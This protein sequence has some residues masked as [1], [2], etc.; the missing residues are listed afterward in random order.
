[1]IDREGRIRS[2][3]QMVGTIVYDET[4]AGE[5]TLLTITIFPRM[6]VGGIWL[7]FV[8]VTQNTT[9]RVKHQIDGTNYRTFET[10]NWTIAMDDGVL[11]T[12]FEAY[13]NVQISFQC[14]GGG[15]GNVNVPYAV[16]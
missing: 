14:G 8:N 5:Q 16:V 7:D 3:P 6:L 9:I 1:M 15:V 2:V 13:R 10:D 11:I 4:N 12:Q